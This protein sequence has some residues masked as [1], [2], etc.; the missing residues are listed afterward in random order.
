VGKRTSSLLVKSN[1]I[2]SG[3]AARVSQL[4]M[5]DEWIVATKV[6]IDDGPIKDKPSSRRRSRGYDG[7]RYNYLVMQAISREIHRGQ[8]NRE[9]NNPLLIPDTNINQNYSLNQVGWC[10]H[11]SDT[12]VVIKNGLKIPGFPCSELATNMAF[13]VSDSKVYTYFKCMMSYRPHALLGYIFLLCC[14]VAFQC[15]SQ[16]FITAL[17]PVVIP[18]FAVTNFIIMLEINMLQ[19]QVGTFIESILNFILKLVQACFAFCHYCITSI[20]CI[21]HNLFIIFIVVGIGI[22][23]YYY[24]EDPHDEVN[25]AMEPEAA[26]PA[27]VTTVIQQIQSAEIFE[28]D[29]VHEYIR[30]IAWVETND[31]L[32]NTT[33]RDGYHGGLWQVDK[34]IFLATQNSSYPILKDKHRLLQIQFDIDWLSV[35]WEELRIPLWSAMAI[36]LHMCTIDEEVPSSISKQGDHWNEHYNKKKEK[37]H[38]PKEFVVKVKEL[39]VNTSGIFY[40]C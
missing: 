17:P 18:I 30:R 39:E 24:T 1:R 36:Y 3:I 2:G 32:D 4:E 35:H 29:H 10:N 8:N 14:P 33:Y 9:N 40:F 22:S 16:P 25:L 31:G 12:P 5:V 6:P 28:K 23:V 20:K 26:G 11:K 34:V 7:N 21:V 27:V 38:P 15:Y 37:P 13:Q 19:L